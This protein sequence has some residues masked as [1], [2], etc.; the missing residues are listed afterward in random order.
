MRAGEEDQLVESDEK[1]TILFMDAN[2][3]HARGE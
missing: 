1:V 3:R 2:W